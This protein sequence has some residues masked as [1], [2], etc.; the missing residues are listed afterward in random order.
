LRAFV[1]QN[2]FGYIGK[3]KIAREKRQEARVTKPSKVGHMISISGTSIDTPFKRC[4][5]ME[6]EKKGLKATNTVT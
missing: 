2:F 6:R 5:A 4:T 1:T 3:K